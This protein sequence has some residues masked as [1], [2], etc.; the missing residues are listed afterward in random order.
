MRRIVI[1]G[2]NFESGGPLSVM[3]DALSYLSKEL[4]NDF[5][6]IALVHSKLLYEDIEKITFIEFIDSRSSWVK[7]IYYEYFYFKKLSQKM[8]VYLWLSMHDITPNV[9][10]HKKAVYCHNPSPF[11]KM[12]KLEKKMDKKLMLFNLFYKYLYQ[13]NI[14]Y[15]DFVIVQQEWLR[16]EFKKLYHIKNVIVAYPN[17]DLTYQ[18]ENVNEEKEKK[19][20]FLC[21]FSKSI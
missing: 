13:I 17:I 1:S 11:Y 21:S 4:S 18:F 15:N 12:S 5:E 7:R 20:F 8:D 6:I 10:S 16:E 19:N 14:R 3:R 9:V 2:I